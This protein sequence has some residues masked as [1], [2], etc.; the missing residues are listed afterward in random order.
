MLRS[1]RPLPAPLRPHEK[2]QEWTVDTSARASIFILVIL[3]GTAQFDRFSWLKVDYR[4]TKWRLTV[5]K[6][7]SFSS[8]L[9]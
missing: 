8:V 5:R 7:A 1:H 9:E 3:L 6:T 2:L 4:S